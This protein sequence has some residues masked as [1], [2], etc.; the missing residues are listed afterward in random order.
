MKRWK[1]VNFETQVPYSIALTIAAYHWFKP[2]MRGLLGNVPDDL[3]AMLGLTKSM[4]DAFS[5][6]RLQVP[7]PLLPDVDL[8]KRL[9]AAQ[10]QRFKKS[11]QTLHSALAAAREAE[12]STEAVTVLARQFGPEFG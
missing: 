8:L 4:L 12:D 2:C 7:L 11:L 10:M 5:A 1:H 9:D 6:T 3:D